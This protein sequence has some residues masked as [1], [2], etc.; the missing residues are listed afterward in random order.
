MYCEHASCASLSSG[1]EEP[2]SSPLC[3]PRH[4]LAKFLSAASFCMI[5]NYLPGAS[6]D[7]IVSVTN[8]RTCV[9]RNTCIRTLFKLAHC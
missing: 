8:I 1:R 9:C 7:R 2:I 4:V 3:L 6:S 5:S